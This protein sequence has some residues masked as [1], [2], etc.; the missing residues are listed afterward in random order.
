M[1][2]RKNHDIFSSFNDMKTIFI[3]IKDFISKPPINTRQWKVI[4]LIPISCLLLIL[5]TLFITPPA[6]GY[7]L[8]LH[9]IYPPYFWILFGTIALLPLIYLLFTYIRWERFSWKTLYCLT[10]FTIISSVLFRYIPLIRGY[11]SYSGCDLHTHYGTI[12][13]ILE[14]GFVNSH[15]PYVHTE[16][17]II[18]Q[19]SGISKELAAYHFDGFS[20]FFFL[21]SLFIVG[22]YFFKNKLYT[23]ILITLVGIPSGFGELLMPSGWAYFLL[24]IYIYMACK[25][26]LEKELRGTYLIL[27]MLFTIIGWFVHP[28]FV[29]YALIVLGIIGGMYCL[30]QIY[31]EKMKKSN[32][33][34]ARISITFLLFTF[35]LSFLGGGFLLIFSQTSAFAGQIAIFS[36]IYEGMLN[37][38]SALLNILSPNNISEVL[39]AVPDSGYVPNSEIQEVVINPTNVPEATL[40]TNQRS[41][42]LSFGNVE[43]SMLSQFF[44]SSLSIF[45]RLIFA[46]YSYGKYVLFAGVAVVFIVLSLFERG[47]KKLSLVNKIVILIFVSYTLF[48]FLNIVLGTTI[49]VHPTRMLKFVNFF[50]LIVIS[51][52]GIEYILSKPWKFIKKCALISLVF[53]VIVC[54]SLSLSIAYGNPEMNSYNHP[55]TNQDYY[56]MEL[57]YEHRSDNYLIEELSGREFQQ[58]YYQYIFGAQTPIERNIRSPS[59]LVLASRIIDRTHLGYD[60]YNYAG[61]LYDDKRYQLIYQPIGQYRKY[62][63]NKDYFHGGMSDTDLHHLHSD[64]SVIKVQDVGEMEVH[65]ISPYSN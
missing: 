12:I 3:N 15:Y 45:E 33:I 60:R 51:T 10:F 22:N 8:S 29:L 31:C 43:T 56:G 1:N 42:S 61:E 6:S 39:N 58:R 37:I 62:F 40:N 50:A 25:C 41:N 30:H 17:A 26:I 59:S 18:S 28:E 52:V 5:G 36:N 38:G 24:P 57:F 14:T 35:I 46:F 55:I 13:S 32:R 9:D 49:G 44:S 53:I 27:T 64:L 16:T 20:Y 23:I 21:V 54:T 11:L 19:I 47:V 65:L 34:Y 63:I 2:S 4:A 48:A 7:E